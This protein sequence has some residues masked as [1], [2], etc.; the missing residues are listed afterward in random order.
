M[1]F[2]KKGRVPMKLQNQISQWL[3][4]KKKVKYLVLFF[5]CGV[6]LM[7]LPDAGNAASADGVQAEAD[8]VFSVE[9]EEARLEKVLGSIQG[10]GKC[11]VLLSVRT[12]TE[13]ILAE[14]E[15][16]TV[17]VSKNGSQ[18]TVTVQ[19]KYPDFQGAVIVASG[20]GDANVRYDILSAVMAY[21][22]LGADKITIC[23]IE[24]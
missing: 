3:N 23:P 16:E 7:L 8:T 9:N 21:T 14:D 13:T 11:K 5:L 18:S 2:Q 1:G 15:G 12:G 4:D 6:M 20:C 22:G 19:T 24:E 17:V 10:V